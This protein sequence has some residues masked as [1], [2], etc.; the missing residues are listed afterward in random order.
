MNLRIIVAVLIIGL[1]TA[2][3]AGCIHD[4]G[5]DGIGGVIQTALDSGGDLKKF[6]STDEL[7][8]FLKEAGR[9]GYPYYYRGS[10]GVIEEIT[11]I[12]EAPVPVA[13]PSFVE[14]A[15]TGETYATDYSRTNIQVEGVDEADF[16]KN[17]GKYIYI[18][19]QKRLVII[20]AYPPE[21]A[22]IVSDVE[23]EGTPVD[24]YVNGD[25]LALFSREYDEIE[26]IPPY[27]YMPRPQRREMTHLHIYDISDRE[28]PEQIEDLA[29]SG[30]YYQ[31]RMIGDYIYF[32]T[33]ETPLY[34]GDF[35]E[36]PVIKPLVGN[37]LNPDI[38]YFGNPEDSYTFT[39]VASV[40]IKDPDE[41]NARTF[42]MGYSN[43]LYVSANSIYI[44]YQKHLP[45]RYS[46]VLQKERFNEVIL[47][48]LPEDVQDK[49]RDIQKDESL[50]SYEQW[51]RISEVLERM[52]N[53]MDED[54][55]RRLI[56][57]IEEAVR[58]WEN[59]IE[60]EMRKTVIHKIRIDGGNIE[61]EG[62]G[63]VEGYP[64]NQFSMDEYQGYFRIAT[65]TSFWNRDRGYVEYNNLY[66]LDEK[67]EVVGELKR[68]AENERI[69]STRFMGDR[70]YM[71]TFKR[72][73]PLF[74]IDLS[75]P[76]NPVVLGKLKIPGFSDYL[77]PYDERHI[78]G[79]GKETEESSWGG[80]S[81]DGLKLALFD[82]SDP[83]HPKEVD[84]VVI[85]E[86]GTDSEALVDHKAFLFDRKRNLLVIPVREV[87]DDRVYGPWEVWQGAY[88]F[89][90]TIEDG[91]TLRGKIT[92]FEGE[93]KWYWHSPAAVRRSLYMDDVLYT[94]SE[95]CIKMNDLS[96]LHEINEVELPI[97]EKT[98]YPIR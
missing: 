7:I 34:Y 17:D 18:I 47:P 93:D 59:K 42:L 60:A 49:I 16:V 75:D 89:N 2:L 6:N 12:P 19:S 28:K 67:M 25:R 46:E 78:I 48:H 20:D 39:M 1:L 27:D 74:V 97:D 58:E 85:G 77:H 55:K 15:S 29:T 57:E 61:Y 84:K 68:I 13:T 63:E 31:S 40:D 22:T 56:D 92:H 96:T 44:T 43:T 64:L 80:V 45:Y 32:V 26:A 14:K 95:R 71:V 41:L 98:Y 66:V 24:M 69:Y 36:L 8:E 87:V 88:V 53:G 83:E 3:T 91:F 11:S 4:G 5:K 37:A 82:V 9:T 23:I 62:R 30:C 65:T 70:L 72:T 94:I 86:R 52:Y 54:E 81:I 21:N 79:I 10:G 51:E 35:V 50:S 90:L 38:Y 76:E 73:D 33:R